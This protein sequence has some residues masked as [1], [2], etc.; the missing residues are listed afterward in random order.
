MI[1]LT[2]GK[3]KKGT[4]LQ[5][6]KRIYHH[7]E[8]WECYKAGFYNTTAPEGIDND[9]ALLMYAYF[10]SDIGRFQEATHK[11]FNNWPNSCE[12]FLTNQNINRIAW[13]GQ[14]SM[15]IATGI[16]SKY[17]GGFRLLT[18]KQQYDANNAAEEMLN[19]WIE[20]RNT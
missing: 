10:L 5:K 7:W 18:D 12:Q 17:K 8:K 16:P 6:I 3:L 20:S 11:V 2:V 4:S 15:C 9:S 19:K 13:I 1:F 14:S